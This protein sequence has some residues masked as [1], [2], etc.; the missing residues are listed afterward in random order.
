MLKERRVS[1]T[2]ESERITVMSALGM[3]SRVRKFFTWPQSETVRSVE[4]CFLSCG[5]F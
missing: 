1:M 2:E 4:G 3:P 5:S